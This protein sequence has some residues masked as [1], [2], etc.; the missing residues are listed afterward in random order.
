MQETKSAAK[1]AE[2]T[3][4]ELSGA[5]REF[6]QQGADFAKNVSDKTKATAEDATKAAG[7]VYSTFATGAVDF[8]RQCIETVRATTNANLDF[9][10]QLLGVKSP[11]A[12]VELTAEHTRKQVEAFAEQT[13]H[14]TGMAQKITTEAVAPLQASVKSAFN[15]AA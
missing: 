4:S 6:A 8:H 11:S 7:E 14:L 13:R 5:A 1:H 2:K 9:I 15:R 10:H 12:F 3:V